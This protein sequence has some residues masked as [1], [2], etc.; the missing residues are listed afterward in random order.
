MPLQV[1]V[2]LVLSHLAVLL[3]VLLADLLVAH[4]VA[5]LVALL[6]DLGSRLE[7]DK[8]FPTLEVLSVRVF[9]RLNPV[10]L[11]VLA[12]RVR[13]VLLDLRVLL[14]PAVVVLAVVDQTD[15][16]LGS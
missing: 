14:G 15:A 7:M 10:L 9:F 5:H 1:P 3:A 8:I 12:R 2:S 13:L 6:A 16:E 4:V 11:A